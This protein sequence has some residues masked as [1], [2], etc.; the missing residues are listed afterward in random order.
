MGSRFDQREHQPAADLSM[1]YTVA[2]LILFC[3]CPGSPLTGDSIN[4]FTLP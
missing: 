2:L 1:K 4:A 3:A